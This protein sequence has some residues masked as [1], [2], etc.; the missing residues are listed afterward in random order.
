MTKFIIGLAVGIGLTLI[1]Y[2]NNPIE[3]IKVKTEWQERIVELPVKV[4]TL[5]KT[6]Q[7]TKIVQKLVTV[8]D[9]VRLI[10]V[11]TVYIDRRRVIKSTFEYRPIE[12]NL[13]AQGFSDSRI[14]SIVFTH[15]INEDYIN[16]MIQSHQ[17][18]PDWKKGA[19][20]GA[21]VLT[22]AGLVWLIK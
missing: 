6:I 9:T 21:G 3:I 14:D 19:W 13:I 16:G 15:K 8:R 5:Y 20:F 18:Y 22:T 2:F 10:N 11:D 7:R 12:F 4:D 17:H 1:F